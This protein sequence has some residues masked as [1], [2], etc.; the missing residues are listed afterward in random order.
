MSA[1]FQGVQMS[2]T[3]PSWLDEPLASAVAALPERERQVIEALFFEERSFGDIAR[4]ST[5]GFK[6][7]DRKAVS[8]TR[9]KGLRALRHSLERLLG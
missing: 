2:D 1:Q 7:T 9:D 4:D 3:T 5:F 8:R 6:P